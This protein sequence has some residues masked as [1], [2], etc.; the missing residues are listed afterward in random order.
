VRSKRTFTEQQRRTQLVAAAI[1]VIAERGYVN[2]SL[3]AVA[4]RAGTSKGV[5]LY[6]F[7]GKDDLV[8]AVVADVTATAREML[9]PR[10][11]DA[12]GPRERLQAYISERIGFLATHATAMR[13]LLDIAIS[14]R[15]PEGGQVHSEV[16]PELAVTD[17]EA[18]L[19]AGQAEGDFRDFALRPMALSIS[20]AI[21]GVL[22]QLASR[23]DL[24]LALWAREIATTFD[25]ATRR[26][27]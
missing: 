27:P 21:D 19:A 17:I 3:S 5:L 24:D 13:A 2:A 7:A 4:E 26:T 9:G 18:L 12:G 23:P 6:H 14:G 25:T 11:R 15:T 1:E 10:I 8:S 16:G 20:Q 22:L